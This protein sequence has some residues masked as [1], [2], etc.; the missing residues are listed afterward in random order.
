MEMTEERKKN[1]KEFGT[2]T[3]SGIVC[4]KCG[5]TLP[6]IFAADHLDVE[7]STNYCPHKPEYIIEN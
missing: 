7:F 4:N 6:E 3:V 5:E 1:F 2:A